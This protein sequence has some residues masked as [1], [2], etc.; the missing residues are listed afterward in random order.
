MARSDQRVGIVLVNYNGMRFMP[1]CLAS[2]QQMGEPQA[3][4]VVVDNASTD[5]SAAWVAEHY[6]SVAL[7]QL[8][9]NGGVTGGNNAGIEW[10]LANGCDYILLLNNDTVVEPDFLQHLLLHTDARTMTVPRVYFYD[11][12]QLLNSHIGHFDFWRGVNVQ[13]LYGKPESASSRQMQ[14]VTMASTCAMLI[15]KAIIDEVG[16]MDDAYFLYYDDTDFIARAVK[17]GAVIKYIPEAVIYHRE[18]SSSGGW[19]ISPLSM[20]YNTR[21]RLY[22][23]FKHQQQKLILIFFLVYFFLGR[24]VTLARHIVRGETRIATALCKGI[25][26]FFKGNMGRAPAQRF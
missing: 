9:T 11:N 18:S 21:N 2:L 6:P 25:A 10:C 3:K 20:Y 17:H 26:D 23:M 12:R 22:F 7:I 1:D 24:I 8:P 5:G 14:Q 13:Y 19:A 16:I 15:P 4:I